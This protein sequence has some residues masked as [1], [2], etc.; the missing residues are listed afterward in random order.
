MDQPQAPGHVVRCAS[1]KGTG[2][3]QLFPLTQKC[4]VCKGV[5]SVVLK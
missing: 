2:R 1:C 5:G 3:N 4:D